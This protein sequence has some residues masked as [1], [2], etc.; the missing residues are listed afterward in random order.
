MGG[1]VL[2]GSKRNLG[3]D[4]EFRW[5]S[6]YSAAFTSV[7]RGF[8]GCIGQCRRLLRFKSPSIRTIEFP[9]VLSELNCPAQ[10]ESLISG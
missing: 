9:P 4:L 7:L 3:I 5:Y 1:G 8:A 2:V 10:Q 6:R